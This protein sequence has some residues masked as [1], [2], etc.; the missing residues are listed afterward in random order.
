MVVLFCFSSTHS[1]IQA[2]PDHSW[3]I[4]ICFVG[5][6]STSI[7]ILFRSFSPSMEGAVQS[8][9][10]QESRTKY[11]GAVKKSEKNRILGVSSQPIRIPQ[12]SKFGRRV[13]FGAGNF[14]NLSLPCSNVAIFAVS[15]STTSVWLSR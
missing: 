8:H 15:R 2:D 7:G 12:I 4:G 5:A 14:F 11:G 9:G 1:L 6:Q 10:D 3:Q 13:K